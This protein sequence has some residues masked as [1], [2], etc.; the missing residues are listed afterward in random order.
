M[1]SLLA[2]AGI[3][4]AAAS[5][6]DSLFAAE[7]A[8]SQ[9]QTDS[10]VPS[11]ATPAVPAASGSER[12]GPG[13]SGQIQTS[14]TSRFVREDLPGDLEKYVDFY[15]GQEFE[16]AGRL[17]LDA[18]LPDRSRAHM[19]L[20]LDH[21]ASSNV[22]SFA[23]REAFVDAV[24]LGTLSVRAGKQV[25]QWSRCQLWTPADLVNVEAPRF[26][27]RLGAR[28]GAVGARAH[29]P[30]GAGYNLYGFVDAGGVRKPSDVAAVGRFEFTLPHTEVGLTWRH[31]DGERDVPAIDLS[32]GYS[33]WQVA[34]EA[35]WLAPGTLRRI[36]ISDPDSGMRQAS[37]VGVDRRAPQVSLSVQ[38]PFDAFGRTDR[39]RLGVEGFWNPEGESR[40]LFGDIARAARFDRPVFLGRDT[41]FTG[42][43]AALL[44]FGGGYRPY[45]L[46]RHYL[47]GFATFS[48][49]FVNSG[50]LQISALGNLD[51]GSWQ[52]LAEWSWESLHGLE[53]SLSVS[54]PFGSYPGEFTWT[55]DYSTLR[56]D[57]G[58]RF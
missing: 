46:N 6:E 48:D 16:T 45:Q 10:V 14:S 22:A 37:I 47:M 54:V 50:T 34:M 26:Q 49:A 58:I 41:I 40:N 39:L 56:A 44:V 32:T 42:P 7:A 2:L 19:T 33:R 53:F 18:P 43:E 4:T 51:D 28:E 17:D 8:P 5:L 23:M 1:I 57:L 3:A 24:F 36:R 25:L 52:G 12:Q 55:S 20:E 30:L 15:P 35:A 27:A 29:L 38:R 9:V 21:L 13:I 31:K 11:S